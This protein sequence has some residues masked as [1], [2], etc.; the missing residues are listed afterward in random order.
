MKIPTTKNSNF[1]DGWM[2]SAEKLSCGWTQNSLLADFVSKLFVDTKN[3]GK[4]YLT[5]A[6]S[7]LPRHAAETF[8]LINFYLPETFHSSS[9]RS[10]EKIFVNFTKSCES[11]N[12]FS[13]SKMISATKYF[14]RRRSFQSEAH[15][16]FV[17][18]SPTLLKLAKISDVP[19]WQ[20]LQTSNFFCPRQPKVLK[21]KVQ[22]Y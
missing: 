16:I 3:L 1:F 22:I 12:F 6:N 17:G 21:V 10:C 14:T 2:K 7:R 13:A 11:F 5:F 18:N 8:L 15:K 4:L 9:V 20:N 19:T